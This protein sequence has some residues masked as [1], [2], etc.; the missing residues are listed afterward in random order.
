MGV[1]FALLG[2]HA[3]PAIESTSCTSLPDARKSEEALP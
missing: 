3:E 2:N 1:E